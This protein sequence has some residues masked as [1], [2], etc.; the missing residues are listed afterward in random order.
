MEISE[1]LSKVDH[2]CLSL[3]AGAKDIEKTVDEA[4]AYKT[5]AV[6]VPP[7]FVGEAVRRSAGRVPV[8]VVT[9]FPNGYDST[10]AK[11]RETEY[12]LEQGAAET[13]TVLNIA[14]FVYGDYA[15]CL[16]ELEELKKLHGDRVL[17]VIVECCL[18]TDEQKADACRLVA[19]S[20]AD[21]IK[22]STGFQKGG[23][24]VEDVALFK[25]YAPERL[26]IKAAGGIRDIRFA[27]ELI[28]AGASRIGAS[29][30]IPRADR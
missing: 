25:K 29:G 22:T 5:A 20:G 9:G 21:Y 18:L 19:D 26:K 3:T 15:Y 14:R 7:S 16:K 2:T 23:A 4:I 6:C 27:E 1:I 17:K 24:T 12:C 30:L 10:A 8:A 28:L 13:D 11:L